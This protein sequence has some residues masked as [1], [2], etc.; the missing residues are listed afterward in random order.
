M[1]KVVSIPIVELKPSKTK[2]ESNSLNF[3]LQKPLLI[4]TVSIAP[5]SL[6]HAFGKYY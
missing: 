1:S 2:I 3:W 4:Q 5:N 6:K